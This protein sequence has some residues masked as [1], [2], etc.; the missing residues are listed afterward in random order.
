M[1]EKMSRAVDNPFQIRY[2]NYM[3]KAMKKTMKKNTKKAAKEAVKNTVFALLLISLGISTAAL[4]YLHFFASA[5]RDL[6]GE[7]TACLDMTGQAATT[8]YVWLQ[9]IEAVSV[10]LEELESRMHGLTIQVNLTMEQ[11]G[12]F[13]GTFQCGIRPESYEACKEAAYEAFS[14]V[15][16][17]LLSE[18]LRM[19]G[20]EGSMDREAVEDLVEETFG[21]SACAYLKSCG[22]ALLPSLEELQSRYDG[23]GGYE[24]A[25]GILTRAF[26][27]GGAV[28]M[29]EERYI[30]QGASLILFEKAD[31]GQSG[32]P[33]G[34]SSGHS[35][36]LYT[37]EQS[38]DK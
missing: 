19:A 26:D 10:S 36:L 23:S 22:P 16:L 15:F 20:Y 38:S 34:T 30:R 14:A 32:S 17:E 2:R 25:E 13:K 9:D 24:A 37:L 28:S 12:R 1:R 4:A 31:S 11:T 27:T 33:A 5:D 7:W 21:M 35:P 29:R 18:R 3:R 6:T 8:A